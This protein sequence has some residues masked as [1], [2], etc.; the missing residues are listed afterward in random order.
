[1]EIPDRLSVAV[2]FLVCAVVGLVVLWR[3]WANRHKADYCELG[4][5]P[6]GAYVL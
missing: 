6:S 1:V 2:T 4:L 5:V 3:K